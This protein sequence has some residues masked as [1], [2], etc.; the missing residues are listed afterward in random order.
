MIN[1]KTQVAA[2]GNKMGKKDQKKKE[3]S[4][5]GEIDLSKHYYLILEILMLS[6]VQAPHCL[7]DYCIS[8]HQKVLKYP[9]LS[10]IVEKTT[11]HDEPMIQNMV[12]NYDKL[13]SE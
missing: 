7:R 5:D 13:L 8:Q 2:F 1:T 10:H 12:V 3:G 4:S 11:S 9:L 6:L